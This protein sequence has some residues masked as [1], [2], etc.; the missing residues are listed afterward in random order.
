MDKNSFGLENGLVPNRQQV[1]IWI[2]DDIV[3]WCIY[4]R[5][6]ATMS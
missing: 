1:L 6:S 5:S 3:S 4:M 2:D